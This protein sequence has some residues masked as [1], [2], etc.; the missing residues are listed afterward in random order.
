MT[1]PSRSSTACTLSSP[2]PGHRKTVSVTMAP[3]I[4]APKSRPTAV[5][6]GTSA[7]RSAW[8]MTTRQPGKPFARA[9]RTQSCCE[10]PGHLVAHEARVVRG[11][12]DAE[13]ERGQDEAARVIGE[14]RC[15]SRRGATSRAR[16]R[17][18]TAGATQ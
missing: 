5:T 10:Q 3:P 9:V 13:R 7:L 2:R 18:R 1:G 16:A 12:V 14:G 8:R 17:G 4:S 11:A 6:M 15:R